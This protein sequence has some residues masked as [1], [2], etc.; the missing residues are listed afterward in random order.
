[1]ALKLEDISQYLGQVVHDVYGR[2]IGTVVAIYSEV[3]GTV[4]AIEVSKN[5]EIYETIPAERLECCSDGLKVEPEWLAKAKIIERKLDTL[6][7]RV[8]ALEDLF[9]RNQIPEHAYKELKEKLSKELEKAQNEAKDLKEVLRKRMYELEN[10]ILRIEKAMTHLMVSYTAGELPQ[11][12]FEASMNY[13]RFAK[14]N[15]QDEKKDIEKHMEKVNKLLEEVSSLFEKSEEQAEI[16]ASLPG[17]MVVKVME[18][19]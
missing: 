4:T 3:D 7:K 6:R 18:G 19:L 5:D 13:M 17:P 1:M 9:S 10:F 11:Q 16:T 8:K 2:R 15:A 12:G 14:Q